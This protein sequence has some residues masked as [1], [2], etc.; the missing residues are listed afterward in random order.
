M[1]NK[2][3]LS[4]VAAIV[5]A[6]IA[7]ASPASTASSDT[8]PIFTAQNVTFTASVFDEASGQQV[9]G[10]IR[11]ERFTGE[12]DT[13]FVDGFHPELTPDVSQPYSFTGLTDGRYLVIAQNQET[14]HLAID[15]MFEMT[16]TSGAIS[17]FHVADQPNA[18]VSPNAGVYELNTNQANFFAEVL[19]SDGSPVVL[20]DSQYLSGL[21][22]KWDGT[23]WIG[24][25]WLDRYEVRN[26][27]DQIVETGIKGRVLDVSGNYRIRVTPVGIAGAVESISEEFSISSV[28]Q[29][30][31]RVADVQL[32]PAEMQVNV[33]APGSSSGI[34]E[35]SVRL[36]T[37]DCCE[38]FY[39]ARGDVPIGMKFPAAGTYEI[40]VSTQNTGFADLSAKKYSVVV[41]LVEGRL[42]GAVTGVTPVNGVYNL[43]LGTSNFSAKVVNPTD[44]AVVIDNAQITIFEA[45]GGERRDYVVDGW[46]QNG[47]TLSF[48]LD[49]GTYFAEV[50]PEDGNYLLA[51]NSYLI[52]ISNSGSTVAV[53]TNESSPTAVSPDGN[54]VY[55]LA[56]SQA[57]LVG[58]VVDVN[59]QPIV[60]NWQQRKWVSVDLTKSNGDYYE[61]VGNSNVDDQGRFSF[62]VSSAG[63]YRVEIRPQGYS[64]SANLSFDFTL[65]EGELSSTTTLEYPTVG[66]GEI[67]LP[68]PDL[69][70][71]VR[72]PGGSTNLSSVQIEVFRDGEYIS[73][74]NTASS[75]IAALTLPSAG[76]YEIRI[77]PPRSATGTARAS[78]SATLTL[79]GDPVE[80]SVVV[81]GI[82]P[83]DGIHTLEL[84]VPTLSGELTSPDGSQTIRD[85]EVIPVDRSTGQDAWEYSGR[86]N[87][88]GQFSMALPEGEWDIYARAPHGDTTMGD[89]DRI[90]PVVVD[91][92]GVATSVPAGFTAA[93]FDISLN[94]PTWTGVMV[95]PTDPSQ[96]LTNGNVCLATGAFELRTWSCSQTNGL[97]EWALSKPT[98]FTGFSA[99]DELFINEWGTRNFAE[100]RVRGEA[101]IEALL[102]PWVDGETFSG[103]ELSPAA[104]N[105]RVFVQAGV[106]DNSQPVPARNVWVGVDDGREWLGGGSTNAQGFASI[107]IP[108]D[109]LGA[110]LNVQANIEHNASLNQDFAA[111][112]KVF[113]AEVTPANPRVLEVALATPNFRLTVAEPG[114]TNL[115]SY[116][117][118]EVMNDASGEWIGGS[119]TSN[120][121]FAAINLPASSTYRVTVN[122]AWNAGAE[123][124]KNTYTVVVDGDGNLTG[125]SDRLGAGVTADGATNI[126]AL[127]LGT[128]SVSGVVKDS[129]GNGVRDSWVT[130]I[131][132]NGWEYLWWLGSNSRSGGDFAMNLDDGIYLLEANPSWNNVAGDTK[133]ERCS[134]EVAGASL[135]TSYA[136]GDKCGIV[137]GKVQLSLRAPNVTFTLLEPDALTTV[138][139]ANVGMFLGNWSVWTQSDRNG[140]VAINLDE[141]EIK[142]R[143][144]LTAAQSY[145]IRIVVEPPYGNSDLARF[146]CNSGDNQELCREIPDFVLDGTQTPTFSSA[147]S[148]G[149]DATFAAPNTRIRVADPSGAPLL[150]RGSW[151]NIFAES[152]VSRNWLSGG[153]S[154]ANGF[155]SFNLDLSNSAQTYTIEVN[156]PHNRRGEFA[157]RTYSGETHADL[158]NGVF[159]LA[160]PNLKLKISDSS[161]LS[162][163]KWAWVGVEVVDPTN[164]NSFLSWVTGAGTDRLGQVSLSLPNAKRYKVMLNP[165]QGTPGSFTSCLFDV[166]G[167]GNVTQVTGSCTGATLNGDVWELSLSAGNVVGEAYYL[168]D[169]SEKVFLSGAIIVASN[170]TDEVTTTTKADGSYAFQLDVGVT[171][172][173]EAF[174]VPKSDDPAFATSTNAVA[175]GTVT[176][177]DTE[178][179][180]D[181]VFIR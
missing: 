17:A 181:A 124:S 40:E 82:S 125:V 59:S 91:S 118:I 12:Y 5:L 180:L 126:Y 47:S 51:S 108:D 90:G 60:T 128:P 158:N 57:N 144:G 107:A 130:P 25:Q 151:V 78:Y 49:D 138:P 7:P 97:G 66:S 86:T 149:F 20:G 154:D 122:P 44:S 95:S 58:T 83:V 64:D 15:S 170:G 45:V 85:T 139:Y 99:D 13:E 157:Q 147:L 166:D 73:N 98:G 94:R 56:V 1:S 179:P 19:S 164:N 26:V 119:N 54:G 41:S 80:R 168:N 62:R 48:A 105:L 43:E 162:P 84:G 109:K 67:V 35:S 74:T 72:A 150:E 110:E 178:Q 10:S 89:S 131:E 145:D 68:E 140:L 55:L 106:D 120:A 127:E 121:G 29:A 112:R 134:V 2:F 36:Y 137:A 132:A 77:S 135:N 11:L 16:I 114:T 113:A 31:Q 159:N 39:T 100:R 93:A 117:W 8:S 34:A 142:Q 155:V 171:W 22:Q 115:I 153:N 152:G 96:V 50:R 103:I 172:T 173:I 175:M 141:N 3:R 167:S 163:A 160:A 116:S 4:T 146:E 37:D 174:Y 79:S 18:T 30:P 65:T 169:S 81:A 38:D 6:L 24:E 23:S 46:S 129:S 21:L 61:W 52:T 123:F 32:L 28:N 69:R 53:T 33:V 27:S 42:V 133:S 9:E 176:P 104:P 87:A 71:A 63:D 177:S 76:T 111:V 143:S 156:P 101:D 75:G 70:I 102:R 165:N 92:S 14:D 136:G 88:F 148:T 161:G